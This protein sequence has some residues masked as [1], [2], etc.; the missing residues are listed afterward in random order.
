MHGT[1]SHFGGNRPR[2]NLIGED[3]MFHT[4][5]EVYAGQPVVCG[6]KSTFV[7]FVRDGM[8]WLVGFAAPVPAR[9]IEAA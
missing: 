1:F 9:S 6:G 4:L 5:Q 2:A 7:Q 3:A 8:V